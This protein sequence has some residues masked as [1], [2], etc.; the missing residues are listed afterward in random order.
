MVKKRKKRD[1]ESETLLSR[2]RM[3]KRRKKRMARCQVKKK[4]RKKRDSGHSGSSSMVQVLTFP[5][6]LSENEGPRLI[7][8]QAAP[9]IPI[10]QTMPTIHP[11][12]K[13]PKRKRN[14]SPDVCG[15]AK[16]MSPLV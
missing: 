1:A 11:A 15:S 10:R 12:T 2:P 16:M 14:H 9:A 7:L 6:S 13:V 8:Q 3:K 5:E 4:R